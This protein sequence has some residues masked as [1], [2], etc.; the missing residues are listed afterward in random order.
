MIWNANRLW[1]HKVL[2]SIVLIMFLIIVNGCESEV[3]KGQESQDATYPEDEMAKPAETVLN[4]GMASKVGTLDPAV[5]MD[6]AAWKITYPCYHRLVQYDGSE[7]KVIAMAAKSWTKSTDGLQYT[8]ELRDD[9]YFDDGSKLDAEAVKFS[10]N[11]ILEIG[12]GPS[13]YFSNLKNIEIVGDYTVKMHLEKP[14][15]PFL[16]TLATNAASIVN[17]RVME[18]QLEGDLGQ[19]YLSGNTMG[20]G[21]YRL[22]AIEIKDEQ[23]A[24]Y[25]LETSSHYRGEAPALEKVN[26][27]VIPETE[28]RLELL[29]KGKLDLAEGIPPELFETVNNYPG[30]EVIKN[31][32]LAANYIYI[33]N[34]REPFNDAPVRRALNY[35]IDYQGLIREVMQGLA[36]EMK[37]PLPDGLWNIAA[38]HPGYE[39]NPEKAREKL[40]QAGLEEGF[41]VNLLYANY[42]PY[43]EAQAHFIKDNLNHL[44]IDVE[45]KD[46]EWPALRD[47]VDQGEFDLCVGYWSPDFAD[48]YMFLHFWY[49]S[50]YFGLK[51]NRAFYQNEVVDKLLEEAATTV[52]REER[53]DL[54]QAVQE[55]ALEEAP[56]I[57]LFQDMSTFAMRKNIAGYTYNPMLE[58]M[59]PFQKMSKQ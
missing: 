3:E 52:N 35:A 19:D 42:R 54:Y 25:I 48:P 23:S 12:E 49:H 24:A 43:W 27:K 5:S 1:L 10:F 34:L 36:V 26:I 20:S 9:I 46:L 47:K 55:I 41:T 51:G 2:W 15:P 44:G 13:G 39:Y 18:H 38:Q 59:Y 33:N 29:E 40:A 57:L 53:I 37:Q 6:N 11:R 22:M 8:F 7:T 56:Y 17:P 31:V 58:N 4:I 50:D 30:V 16:S 28:E 32:S 14:F 21:A 45:L